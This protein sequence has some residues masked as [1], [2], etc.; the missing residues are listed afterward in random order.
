MTF[1]FRTYYSHFGEQFDGYKTV[2]LECAQRTACRRR[3][4]QNRITCNVMQWSEGDTEIL[5]LLEF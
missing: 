4:S 3:P 2:K 1:L 5:L